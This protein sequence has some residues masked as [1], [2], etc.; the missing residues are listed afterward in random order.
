MTREGREARVPLRADDLEPAGRLP[1]GATRA[2]TCFSPPAFR[3][4]E[5]RL[6]EGREV[7]RDRLS[8]DR[9]LVGELGRGRRAERGEPLDQVQPARVGERPEDGV[10]ASVHA[11]LAR[12]RARCP[13][14]APFADVHPRPVGLLVEA[15]ARRCRRRPSGGRGARPPRPSR[16]PRAEPRRPPS[17]SRRAPRAQHRVPRR[18]RT[19]PR[20]APAP[21]A[22]PRPR[23]V[24][25]EDDLPLDL[26]AQPPVACTM[27]NLTVAR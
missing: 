1:S 8:G 4:D 14:R 16:R 10:Y 17:G 9:Q 22:P 27:G 7:L 15:R 11:A 23:P 6:L 3:A 24:D 13:T 2:R 5:P 21:S 18:S 20:A 12:A 19:T 26:H 25:G